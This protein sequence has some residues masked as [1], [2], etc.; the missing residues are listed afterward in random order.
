MIEQSDIVYI[1]EDDESGYV[2]VYLND[3]NYIENK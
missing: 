1:D 2:T 3:G